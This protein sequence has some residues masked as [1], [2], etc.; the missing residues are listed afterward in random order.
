MSV[1]IDPVEKNIFG[2]RNQI[3]LISSSTVQTINDTTGSVTS[4]VGS[5]PTMGV[6]TTN[7][8]ETGVNTV[9]I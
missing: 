1:T 7:I 8:T 9:I 2:V 5:V 4:S 3:M 6:S